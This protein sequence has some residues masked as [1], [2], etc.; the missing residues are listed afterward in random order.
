[1]IR[2]GIE[3]ETGPLEAIMTSP[4]DIEFELMVPDNL[5]R[6]RVGADGRLED[7]PDYLLFDDLVLLGAMQREHAQLVSLLR[8]VTGEVGLH[9]FRGMLA[10]TIGDG[11]VRTALIDA[12]LALEGELHGTPDAALRAIEAQLVGLDTMRLTDALITGYD[13]Y[14]QRRLLRWP[15]PNALFARDLGAVVGDAIVLT[16]AAE[17]ARRRDMLLSRT[18]WSHHPMLAGVDVVDIAEAGPL[19]PAQG[20]HA[21]LE[22]G[23]VQVMS[24]RLV[25][26]GLSIRTT[27][28][29]ARRLAAG[30]FTRGVEVV[31]ACEMPQRRG[32]MHLDTL[33]TRISDDECL[34]F[35]PLTLD[36]DS[37]GIRVHRLTP[38]GEQDA[39][40]D[41]LR[42][43][44][45]EG[46][47][48][49][50]ILCGGR[51]PVTQA[52]EQWSDGANAFALA[53]GVIVAYGRNAQTL[54]ELNAAGYEVV[55]PERFCA[56][57]PMFTGG[58]RRCV[59]PLTG[60][61]LVRGRGGPRCLTFPLRRR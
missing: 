26:V 7:N 13:R 57:A 23:D 33:F 51:D 37:V 22:G 59:I 9:T 29:A 6:W 15:L 2:V 35:P 43:L 12:A 3:S 31:L 47:T 34:V 30:L 48:L 52:R 14:G 61:E 8:A 44:A 16:H 4:P 55:E 1:M 10:A 39:G 21:T 24:S 5:E 60:S 56:N 32:A 46:V 38:H 45:E 42:A 50:P 25:L 28:E 53:P 36:P 19:R 58:G 20:P 18:L 41:L 49:T 27:L 17:P 54:R 11:A 40:S